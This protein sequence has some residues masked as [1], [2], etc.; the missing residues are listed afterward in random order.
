MSLSD[1]L[2]YT[3]GKSVRLMDSEIDL[4]SYIPIDLSD[5]NVALES[6]DFETSKSFSSFINHFLKAHSKTIAYGGYME[7]RLIYNRHQRLE[8]THWTVHETKM[9]FQRNYLYN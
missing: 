8:S 5:S 9:L 3:V 1:F 6:V 2:K 7:K 4:S